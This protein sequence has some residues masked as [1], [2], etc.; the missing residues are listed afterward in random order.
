MNTGHI[1]MQRGPNTESLAVW[2]TKH[3]KKPVKREKFDELE[4]SLV[5]DLTLHHD[6]VA[7]RLNTTPERIYRKRV[8]MGYGYNKRNKKWVDK[9]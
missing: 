2:L 7:Y 4:L 1:T 9:N 5:R 8:R 3:R 6:Y